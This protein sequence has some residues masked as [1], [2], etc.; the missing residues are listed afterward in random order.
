[1][2]QIMYVGGIIELDAWRVVVTL[3]PPAAD[4]YENNYLV[5]NCSAREVAVCRSIKSRGTHLFPPGQ[6]RVFFCARMSAP[7]ITPEGAKREHYPQHK[8]VKKVEGF[9][10]D[11]RRKW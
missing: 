2:Q 10:T 6:C 9:Q 11:R 4:F 1:M 8:K 5:I 7:S 3:F